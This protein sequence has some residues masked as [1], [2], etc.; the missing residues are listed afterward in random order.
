MA[1]LLDFI[2][3][4]RKWAYSLIQRASQPPPAYGSPEWCALPEGSPEKVAAVKVA[5]EC[6]ARRR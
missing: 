2:A 4:R 5:A 1:I 6:H 3:A